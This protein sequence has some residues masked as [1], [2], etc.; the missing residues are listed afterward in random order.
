MKTKLELYTEWLD[1][2]KEALEKQELDVRWLVRQSLKDPRNE[3]VLGKV[4][5]AVREQ[6]EY[7][8]FME[9]LVE[10]QEKEA[11]PTLT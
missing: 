5:Q 9:E 4:Q 6:K 3:E 11:K 2:A 8:K 1:D 10:E 7:I